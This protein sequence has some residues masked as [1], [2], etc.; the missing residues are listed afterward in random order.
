MEITVMLE[1]A[2]LLPPKRLGM[3]CVAVID[4]SPHAKARA[5]A[6]HTCLSCIDK[7]GLA[8]FGKKGVLS[9]AKMLSQDTTMH[10]VAALDLMEII[11][12]KMNG[13]VPRLVRICG[14]N[15]SDK[16]RQLL[17]E[18]WYKSQAKETTNSYVS[19]GSPGHRLQPGSPQ[20]VI[21][22]NLQ[23]EE[24]KPDIFDELPRLSLRHT[25]RDTLK[26]SP[27]KK[28]PEDT[29][30]E[31]YVFNFSA[32]MVGSPTNIESEFA[33]TSTANTYS[34]FNSIDMEPN[35]A[36]AALRARLLKIR[37]KGKTSENA[38]IPDNLDSRN[39]QLGKPTTE[40]ITLKSIDFDGFMATVERLLSQPTPIHEND[41]NLQNC[42]DS[43]KIV[44]AALSKQFHSTMN[45]SEDQLSDLRASL[46]QNV[47]RT[48]G[49]LR[50]YVL[51]NRFSTIE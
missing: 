27:R 21:S 3:V 30:I 20:K 47:D 19:T 34:Y 50:R 2:G 23:R 44:H 46:A 25:E 4:S 14:P 49:L 37:E 12:S 8:G 5:H 11:L 18:R 36:A 7:T 48:I 9:T 6:C 40:P 1:N 28:F 24:R 43:L 42:I 13:D 38:A 16:A 31:P 45:P 17:E 15:L 51:E 32:G 29:S 10:R 33:E 39:T 22:V 41:G 26:P 35:G